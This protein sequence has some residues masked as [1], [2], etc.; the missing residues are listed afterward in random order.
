MRRALFIA[1]ITVVAIPLA[2]ATGPS[3]AMASAC[4]GDKPSGA[5]T[6]VT[7]YHVT[8]EDHLI[9]MSRNQD[10]SLSGNYLQKNNITF[11]PATL[12]ACPWIPIGTRVP[13]TTPVEKP[14]VGIYD[15]GG[16]TISGL[17]IDRPTEQFVA[18]F[19][20]VRTLASAPL[21]VIRNL[22][23]TNAQITGL[24]YVGGLVGQNI[25]GMITNVSVEA[26]VT[27]TTLIGALAGENLEGKISG[28]RASG[29]VSGG[30]SAGGLVGYNSGRIT[31][32]H[33]V[34]SVTGTA[35]TGGLVGMNQYTDPTNRRGV[36]EQSFAL[37]QTTGTDGVGGLVGFNSQGEILNSFASGATTGT[38]SV[39]GLV[40]E[41]FLQSLGQI[42]NSYSAGL[43]TGT[44]G[45]LGGLV[46]KH[47]GT[48]PVA[49]SFWS[50]VLSG[51]ATS[52][53]G[54]SKSVQEIRSLATYT[55]ITA[56][57]AE[58][59]PIVNGWIASNAPTQIWGICSSVNSGYPFLLWRYES[60]P[61]T[62]SSSA[63]ITTSA[64]HL[65]F[66]ASV[67][68][69]TSAVRVLMEGQSLQVGSPYSLVVRSTPY[70]LKTGVVPPSGQF[71][72]K[73]ALPAGLP[74]GTHTITLQ[75]LSGTGATL[76]L[77]QSFVVDDQGKVAS[78]GPVASSTSTGLAATGTPGSMLIM[79]GALSALL[80]C[81]GFGVM[82]LRHRHIR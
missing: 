74:A 56:G 69:Q 68:Q 72:H 18:L 79:G 16:H 33:S 7:P 71:S 75:A 21:A 39:G 47:T 73:L 80:L 10:E 53:G 23:L 48:V 63:P 76:I 5:G 43:V 65:D 46:G 25:G 6:S 38:S 26:A 55:T 3:P 61:C 12:S 66:Q 2:M 82:I 41:D 27:G 15:G 24:E 40:G 1:L 32:S 54:T 13:G 44:A 62:T 70:T 4:A 50:P 59:W 31:Q 34:A 64:I 9:W 45:D 57:L 28:S 81:L 22:T 14:F 37:G 67:G 11:S 58:S 77:T 8:T 60:D 78:I 51:Q 19:G 42:R 49:D 20:H 36:I 35:R 29:V 30:S 52:S 17:T